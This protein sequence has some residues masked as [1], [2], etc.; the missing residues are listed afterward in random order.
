MEART[1]KVNYRTSSPVTRTFVSKSYPTITK[2]QYNDVMLIFQQNNTGK[3]CP[4]FCLVKLII[5][6]K[7]NLSIGKNYL[8]LTRSK[9]S[10][11]RS[12]KK[13][14]VF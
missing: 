10:Q 3:K 14:R 4:E 9:I 12:L 1:G 2:E 8:Q 5:T 7:V 11:K 6:F 13:I